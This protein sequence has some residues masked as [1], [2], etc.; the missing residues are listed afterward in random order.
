MKKDYFSKLADAFSSLFPPR[1]SYKDYETVLYVAMQEEHKAKQELFDYDLIQYPKIVR[2]LKNRGYLLTKD[3]IV[4][5]LW[6]YCLR[7]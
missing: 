5:Y 2:D 4:Q 7:K 1:W 6:K 3:N